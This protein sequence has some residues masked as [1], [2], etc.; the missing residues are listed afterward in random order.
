M[1]KRQGRFE[2]PKWADVVTTSKSRELPPSDPHCLHGPQDLHSRR[3]RRRRLPQGLWWTVAP[4]YDDEHLLQVLW[5][6]CEVHLA[7]A[8]GDGFGGTGRERWPQDHQGGP[9]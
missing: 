9:A 7:A 6:N 1:K 4:W 5:Q 3:H 8:R 2:I